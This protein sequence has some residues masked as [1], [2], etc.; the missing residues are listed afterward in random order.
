MSVLEGIGFE[1]ARSGTWLPLGNEYLYYFMLKV[2]QLPGEVDNPD[3]IGNTISTWVYLAV[4][5]KR[6]RPGGTDGLQGP[7]FF[8]FKSSTFQ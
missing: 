2:Q 5:S 1:R 8:Y 6:Y 3:L 7:D 4:G